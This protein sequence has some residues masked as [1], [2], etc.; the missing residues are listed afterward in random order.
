MSDLVSQST[1]LVVLV[2]FVAS[3][4]GLLVARR[5]LASAVIANTGGVVTLLASSYVLYGVHHGPFTP[6]VSTIGALPLGQLR[7]PL[8]LL[9]D[10]LSAIVVVAVAIVGLAIQLFTKW[11]LHDDD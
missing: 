1:R 2:P 9:V 6:E 8:H 11:Y 3:L 10:D 4:L 7:M 5:R